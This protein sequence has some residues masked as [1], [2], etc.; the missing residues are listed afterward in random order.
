MKVRMEPA[1]PVVPLT[2]CV[3][4]QGET[5]L[6]VL[7]FW[8]RRSPALRKF[9]ALAFVV[10]AS[11]SRVLSI[12]PYRHATR[13]TRIH[14]STYPSSHACRQPTYPSSHACRQPTMCTDSAD[15][16]L[17]ALHKASADDASVLTLEYGPYMN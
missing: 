1:Y 12:V 15:E 11:R 4:L 16:S 8:E 6:T 14:R 3:R 9:L 13:P 5:G 17:N 7:V 10:V 2:A